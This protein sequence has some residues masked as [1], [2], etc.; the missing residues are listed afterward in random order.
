MIM[1]VSVIIPAFNEESSIGKVIH[2]IPRRLVNEVVV[3]NNNSSDNTEMEAIGAG[4]TVLNEEIRGYGA[5]CL[6]GIGYLKKGNTDIVV[7]LDGDYSDYPEEMELLLNPILEEDYDFVLGSRVK[8]RREAGSMPLHS[9]LGNILSGILI[10]FFWNVKYT[11][12]GPFRAIKFEKLLQL[13]VEDRW[14][15]W[16]VEMQIKAAKQKL[17]ILEVPVSYRRRIGKSKVSG[18]IK[19]SFMAGTIILKTIFVQIFKK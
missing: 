11:D 17:K 4:A 9:R 15:G 3:V 7:F 1:N 5:S 14:Y 16:T 19:G 6:K 8:G 12:L 2:D 13:D 18:T 10:N